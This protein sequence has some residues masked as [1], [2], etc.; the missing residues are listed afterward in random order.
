MNLNNDNK[1]M[2]GEGGAPDEATNRFGGV[3]HALG[4]RI[5]QVESSASGGVDRGRVASSGDAEGPASMSGGVAGV[6]KGH[7]RWGKVANLPFEVRE[8]VNAEMRD[9][10]T[11]SEI[12]ARLAEKGFSGLKKWDLS[13][14]RHGGHQDWLQEQERVAALQA[15]LGRVFNALGEIDENQREGFERFNELLIATQILHALQDLQSGK[16]ASLIQSKPEVFFRIARAASDQARDR[17]RRKRM[18]L[19]FQRYRDHV[20]KQKKELVSAV[21]KAEG[22]SEEGLAE[23]HKAMRLL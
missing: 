17:G 6:L 3:D 18:E 4:I 1:N 8:W 15:D 9:G 13:R 11:Y 14:W 21:E 12:L 20:A 16:L 10:R 23:I 7:K 19:A 22:I 5:P 2:G